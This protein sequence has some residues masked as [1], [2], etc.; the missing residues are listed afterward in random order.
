MSKS[1]RMKNKRLWRCRKCGYIHEG[2]EPPARCP[3]CGA[4]RDAFEPFRQ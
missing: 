1:K 4:G 2:I 3:V